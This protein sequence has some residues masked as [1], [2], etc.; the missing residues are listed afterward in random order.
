MNTVMHNAM[1]VV[2]F[3]VLAFMV[4]GLILTDGNGHWRFGGR[5]R[6]P[7]PV[8]PDDNE[9]KGPRKPPRWAYVGGIM[10][11]R[12]RTATGFF[13]DFAN[14]EDR[15]RSLQYDESLDG[16]AMEEEAY[17]LCAEWNAAGSTDSA[18]EGSRQIDH[19]GSSGYKV[20]DSFLM[21]S[22]NGHTYSIVVANVNE[23]RPPECRYA[24]E[25]TDVTTGVS[26]PDLLFFGDAELAGYEMQ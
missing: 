7:Q 17:R 19:G 21:K 26:A 11:N 14:G 6:E 22:S 23:F 9:P 8:D 1:T 5:K 12:N 15:E 10:D 13:H 4:G 2:M 16:S 24:C 20:D 25:V 18:D 3:C